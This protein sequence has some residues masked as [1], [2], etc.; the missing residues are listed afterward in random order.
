MSRLAEDEVVPMKDINVDK[1]KFDAVLQ[2]LIASPPTSMEAAK[3]V[4][5]IRKDGQL[6][7]TKNG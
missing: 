4:P 7:R 6:K 1:P 5:K 3:A 2:R